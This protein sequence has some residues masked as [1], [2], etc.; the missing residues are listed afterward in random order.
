MKKLLKKIVLAF[1]SFFFLISSFLTFLAPSAKAQ[2]PWYS[3][4]P[5]EWY[6]K[7][8]DKETSPSNE[9]FGERYTAAQVQ[10]IVYSLLSNTINAVVGENIPFVVCVLK[11]TDATFILTGC[12]GKLEELLTEIRGIID[13]FVDTRNS[14][15]NIWSNALG[16]EGRSLSGIA[17]LKNTFHN[18]RFASEAKAQTG[19]GFSSLGAVQKLWRGTRNIAYLLL[20]VVAVVFSFMIMFKVKLN[21][22]T[23][24]TV[25]SA[26]PKIIAAMILVTFSYAI[27]GFAI[28]IMYIVIGLISSLFA[29]AGIA[30]SG[31]L[32]V[33]LTYAFISGHT[34][35]FEGFVI[36]E[37]MLIYAITFFVVALITLVTSLMS[38]SI[39]GSLTSVIM[40]I[41]WVWILI[42]VIWYTVK[43]PFVLIKTLVQIYLSIIVAPIQIMLGSLVPQMGF[44]VWFKNLMAHVLVFPVIGA[45]FYLAFFFLIYAVVTALDVAIIHNWAVELVQVFGGFNLGLLGASLW[46]PPLLAPGKVLTPIIFMAISFGAIVLIP[47]VPNML[48]SI[49]M[50]EKFD[51]GSAMNEATGIA[52]GA[53][54]MTGAPF[55]NQARE[56]WSLTTAPNI[57]AGLR[58]FTS[59]GGT[60]NRVSRFF[61]ERRRVATETGRKAGVI[62]P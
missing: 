52:K 54:G 59:R 49:F 9:I 36:L 3:Q 11:A 5:T 61:E 19:F 58:D 22:Q 31:K 57:W 26:L 39:F 25:Q 4:S 41:I 17:Y 43:V 27:A 28:D 21:P 14:T 46:S 32:G 42:L 47:K 33:S 29:T 53:W 24:I 6:I 44:G 30:M 35:L 40:F 56:G 23:V 16:L 34:I 13:K 62:T 8:Y 1:F 10:W 18:V 45:L 60:G 55:V 2:S 48:K 12:Q 50:R 38:A 51:Y 15:N 20:V 37:Y 7:V